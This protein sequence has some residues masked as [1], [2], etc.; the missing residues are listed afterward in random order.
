MAKQISQ[1][2]VFKI[3]TCLFRVTKES[4]AYRPNTGQ[5]KIIEL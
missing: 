2:K 1:G 4:H 3:N 5:T